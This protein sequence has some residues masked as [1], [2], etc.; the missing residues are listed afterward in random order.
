MPS[1][2]D[3]DIAEATIN[4]AIPVDPALESIEFDAPDAPDAPDAS[5]DLIVLDSQPPVATSSANP[6]PTAS[7]R[8]TDRRPSSTPHRS[9][10]QRP[11]NRI[12]NANANAS[13]TPKTPKS[14]KSPKTPWNT[15]KTAQVM[16]WFHD[17]RN[18]GLFNSSKKKDYSPVWK[19]VMDLCQEAWGGN[20][21]KWTEKI[22]S[23]KYDTERKRFQIWKTLME[24]SGVELDRV[25]NLP[26]FTKATFDQFLARYQT[27]SRS[28]TWLEDTPLGDVDVYEGVFFREKPAGNYIREAGGASDASASASAFAALSDLDEDS[29]RDNQVLLDVDSESSDDADY[30]DDDDDDDIVTRPPAPWK[31]TARQRR[32]Q[33]TDPDQTPARES[34]SAVDIPREDVRQRK[35]ANNKGQDLDAFGTSMEAAAVSIS[36]APGARDIATATADLRRLLPAVGITGRERLNCFNSLRSDPLLAAQWV[37]LEESD[38]KEYIEIWKGG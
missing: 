1:Q 2:E 31:L 11:R 7:S 33:A 17:C 26:V 19:E 27:P 14:P 18:R 12:A 24:Y 36:R 6:I 28:L 22:I 5:D 32:R 13:Q 30:D 20:R 34:S 38:K 10:G 16:E 35:K 37:E 29:G 4:V 25:K 3:S 9:R 21:Y 8:R 23:T 15:Q